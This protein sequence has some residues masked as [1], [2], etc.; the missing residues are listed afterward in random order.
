MMVYR[1]YRGVKTASGATFVPRM[2][3]AGIFPSTAA[4]MVAIDNAILSRCVASVTISAPGAVKSGMRSGLTRVV[5]N[6]G[7]ERRDFG[8]VQNRPGRGES[9][10]TAPAEKEGIKGN[11]VVS[12]PVLDAMIATAVLFLFGFVAL[13]AAGVVHS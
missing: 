7:P 12:K 4:A 1:G 9:V 2:K 8:I 11:A 5:G 13:V 6:K 3:S 10:R